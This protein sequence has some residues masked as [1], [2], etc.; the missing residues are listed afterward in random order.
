MI[1]GV[2]KDG[3]PKLNQVDPS[4]MITNFRANSIGRNYEFV[5]ETL[6]NKY[7]IGMTL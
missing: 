6:V 7:K 3:E 2:D 5:N 1:A 4:G